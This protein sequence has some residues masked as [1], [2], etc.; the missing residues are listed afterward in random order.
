M[1]LLETAPEIARLETVRRY[2]VLNLAPEVGLSDLTALAAQVCQ[3]SIAVLGFFDAEQ[4]WVKAQ[5]NLPLTSVPRQYAFLA[6]KRRDPIPDLLVITD[7]LADARWAQHPM[8]VMG[9]R[10]RFYAGVPLVAEGHWLGTL[11]VLDPAPRDL[12]DDQRRGLL[13]VARQV[14]AQLELRRVTADRDDV[15][16]QLAR[17]NIE[18]NDAYDATLE[19]LARALDL[20]DKEVDGHLVRVADITVRLARAMGVPEDALVHIRRG[21]LLHDIGKMVIPD[22]V[23]LKPS[24]LTEDEW[25]VM[26]RHPVYA[27]EMLAT[28]PLLAPALDI[29]YCHHERWDGE[30]YP[31]QLAGEAIPLAARIFSVVDVWDALRSDRPYRPGWRDERVRDYITKR[32]GADFDPAVVEAFMQFDL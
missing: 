1:P 3:T 6:P 25:A 19:S 15:A 11:E 22:S 2:R 9:P 24:A 10:I 32:A 4:F 13:A 26:H 12:S 14:M 23:L 7:T 27:H 8:V 29:P 18:L 30:G 17:A 16:R 31:R 5:H 21:A 28:I 20:R